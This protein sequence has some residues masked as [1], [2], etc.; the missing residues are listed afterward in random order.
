MIPEVD[1]IRSNDEIRA[2]RRRMETSTRRSLIVIEEDRP[3]GIIE[4]RQ[5]MRESDVPASDMIASH[6]RTQFPILTRDMG[7]NE[8]RTHLADV[9]VDRIP[10][11]DADGRLV[12]EVERSSLTHH[13][14]AVDPDD[15]VAFRDTVAPD[16]NVRPRDPDMLL[17]ERHTTPDLAIQAGMDV[18]GSAGHKLGE[19]DEVGLDATSGLSEIMV[20]HGLL[21]RK[22]KRIPTD[23]IDHIEGD[24]V[25]L[26]IDQAEFKSLADI[27]DME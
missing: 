26:A 18:V 15:N 5:I 19:V 17:E 6:M 16:P 24:R 8:A 11:V 10:V 7:L 25:V 9:D 21:G 1:A 14:E 22:H 20:K 4:W 3:V 27:E 23:V 13:Q 2:A 12:G